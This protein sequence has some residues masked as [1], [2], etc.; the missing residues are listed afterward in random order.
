MGESI[1]K[2]KKTWT[3][4]VASRVGFTGMDWAQEW[5]EELR[6]CGLLGPDYIVRAPN[7]SLTAWL[8]STGRAP[9]LVAGL[10]PPP[11]GTR[12]CIARNGGWSTHPMPAGMSRLPLVPRWQRI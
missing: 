9:R 6:S 2:G 10:A 8:Q 5:M 3:R 7:V 11:D 12:G 4:W 1:L